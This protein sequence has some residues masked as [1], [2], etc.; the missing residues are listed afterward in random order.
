MGVPGKP[1]HEKPPT[2]GQLAAGEAASAPARPPGAT[3]IKPGPEAGNPGAS[4][5]LV[6]AAFT[7]DATPED[8]L[9]ASPQWRQFFDICRRIQGFP[10][11]LSIHVGGMLVTGEPLIDMLP[12]ERASM[13][14]LLSL[15]HI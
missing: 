10:R 1:F 5:S 4:P 6:D 2:L 14:G 9:E 3:R 15:I 11:H 8:A 7:G 12:V 13:P